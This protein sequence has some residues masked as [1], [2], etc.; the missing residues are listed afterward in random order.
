MINIFESNSNYIILKGNVNEKKETIRLMYPLIINRLLRFCKITDTSFKDISIHNIKQYL[1]N[2]DNLE[3][4]NCLIIDY[5]GCDKIINLIDL[6]DE[7][8]VCT[9]TND[10]EYENEIIDYLNNDNKM[11]LKIIDLDENLLNNKLKNISSYF[12]LR[13]SDLL[14]FD[15]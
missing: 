14:T 10:T 11:M 12:K 15:M 1:N 9:I 4:L 2:D 5:S 6:Y 3:F 13:S 8:Y 7:N